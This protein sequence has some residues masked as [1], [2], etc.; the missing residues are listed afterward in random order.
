MKKIFTISIFAMLTLYN[1][2][3]TPQSF[4]YQAVIRDASGTALVNQPVSF[5]ISII[6]SS[7]SG[8]VE[9]IET[10]SLSTNALGIVT[11]NIGNGTP[12]TGLFTGINW[13]SSAHY[14]K[15]EADPTGGTSFLDL[16]TT[17]LLSVPYALYSE[18]AGNI[19]TYNSGTGIDITGTTISN[20]AP[21]QNITLTPAGSTN[22]TGSYPNFTISSTDNNTTYSAGNGISITGTTIANTSPDQPITLIQGG[23]TTVS[24]AYPNFTISSTDL[25]SGTPGSINKTIQFNNAGVFGGNTNLMWD[26]SNER[27]G[28]GLTNPTG[29]MVVQG[30][31]SA[32]ATEPLFEVKNKAGQTVFVV[33]QDSVNVFVNDDAI[34]SNRGGFAV[35][36]R[37]NTKAFTNNYLKVTPDNTRIH[38]GDSLTGFGVTDINGG[39]TASYMQMT[40]LNYFIGH[41][42]GYALTT[43]TSNTGIF[44]SF[45]GYQSGYNNTSGK[46]N[47]F[48]GYRSG[49]NNT[50]G[51]NNIFIGDSVGYL[52]TIG[53][54]NIFIGNGSGMLNINGN[55]NIFMGFRSGSSNT[56]GFF[57]VFIGDRSGN[58]NTIGTNNIFIG[59]RNGYNNISGSYNTS[60]G[61]E[62]M[63]NNTI[64]EF[65]TVIGFESLYYN[66]SGSYNTSLGYRALKLNTNG[67]SSTAVGM[68]SLYANT[69]GYSN[70]GSGSYT[71]WQNT[72]G[73][74]NTAMG[75]GSLYNNISGT[76]NSAIG[77]NSLF[78]NV[79]G[80]SLTAVGF[81]ASVLTNDLINST[82]LGASSMVTAS[83][84]VRVGD[85][86]VTSIG[87]FAN[88]TNI[89]DKRFKKDINENVPGL[90][91][92]LKLKPVTY[93][94]D[95]NS[96]ANYFN[97]P[98]SLRNKD[99]EVIKG[100]MLQTGFIAQDVEKAAN[101][102]GFD[103]SG[104]DK[105]KNDA[106]FYGLRYAEFTV[107]LVKAVQELNVKNEQ[108][109]KENENQKKIIGQLIQ[110]IENLE[111]KTK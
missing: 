66:D 68:Y 33:Y 24:G 22:I 78:N 34:Q 62:A 67:S 37:N 72:V 79:S 91:F 110:R 36:G 1:F 53:Y 95:I 28:I 64:G 20:I 32:L 55:H 87:G 12:I 11:L 81:N 27:L 45:I 57:N 49:Y 4:Q 83:N 48:I 47:Y 8:T 65:N 13:G 52:N 61:F 92:I 102:S 74:G 56:S 46:K 80:S 76:F 51:Y 26:N 108:L 109:T 101:E 21:D 104:V 41:Q 10:H 94:L 18:Q 3:Q 70:T 17:Q 44:N 25:N 71:L 43:T 29:R 9:Y 50:N 90:D 85:F 96:I 98:D 107:P 82:A 105:P 93:H 5:Q 30:S 40:P 75:E 35:S 86:N 77:V 54:K 31:V 111:T 84:Q 16:G 100:N 7:I 106:D 88:W 63:F 6:S 60:A 14:L 2:A 42:A 89:S 38:T 59:V 15:V 99:S 103:F 19:P 23:A 73:Y 58:F 39:P 97:T 69:L